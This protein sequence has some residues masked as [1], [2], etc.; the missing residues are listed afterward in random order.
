M[1]WLRRILDLHDRFTIEIFIELDKTT[2]D[3][4]KKLKVRKSNGVYCIH[5]HILS[6]RNITLA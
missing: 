5:Q 4:V 1:G 3:L 2:V 6:K